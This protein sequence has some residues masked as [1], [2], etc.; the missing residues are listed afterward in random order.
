[1]LVTVIEYSS[2]RYAQ[3]PRVFSVHGQALRVKR[4]VRTWLE[5]EKDARSRKEVWKVEADDGRIYVL[6]HHPEAD[7]WEIPDS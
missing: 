4:V 6:V 1:M 5:E 7:L 2:S 3:E